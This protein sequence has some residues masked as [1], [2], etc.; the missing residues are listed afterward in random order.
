MKLRVSHRGARSAALVAVAARLFM[1][2]V[3]D[4]PTTQNGAWLCPLIGG[5]LAAPLVYLLSRQAL[6]PL[7]YA[8]VGAL[9]LVD[10][11][12]VLAATSRSAGYLA[13]DR[14]PAL[15]LSLP[16]ALAALWCLWRG[17]DAVGYAAMIWTR[18]ALA[19]IV[20]VALMQIPCFHAAWLSPVLGEGWRAILDGGVKSAGWI[21]AAASVLALT[22]KNESDARV[23][24][25]L[26]GA[27]LTASLLILLRCMLAP[28]QL[29]GGWLN[30][31]DA[32][33]CNGREPLYLQLPLIVLWFAGLFHLTVCELLAAAGCLKRLFEGLSDRLCAIVAV[34]LALVLSRLA[35]LGA[36]M[37]GLSYWSFAAVGIA[38]ILSCI[39]PKGKGG[40]RACGAEG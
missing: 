33:L 40:E 31:L 34:S 20:A 3:V 12:S 19:L 13:L 37:Q 18:V 4:A 15:L 22:E 16:V 26:L 35:S 36:W 23:L 14:S 7:V 21:A 27:A 8:P 38:V 5:L 1:G 24:L 11:A 30:R 29:R 2:L 25:S 10:A 6:R 28:T 39:L 17:G 9:A 32:L